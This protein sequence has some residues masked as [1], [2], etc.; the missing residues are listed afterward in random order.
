MPYLD[1]E[2]L[3]RSANALGPLPQSVTRL[4]ALLA[5]KDYD[6]REVVRTVE[7][8]ST[9]AGRIVRIANSAVYPG[10]RLSRVGDAIVRVGSGMIQAMAMEALARPEVDLDLSPFGLTTAEYWKHCVAVLSFAEE[11]AKRAKHGV[12]DQLAT[13]AL[14]HDFGKLVLAKHLTP[15]QRASLAASETDRPTADHEML[16]LGVNHAEVSAVVLQVWKLPPDVVAAVQYHHSPQMYDE[17]I[18]HALVVSNQLALR[19]EDHQE[20]YDRDTD[21]RAYSLD[22]LQIREPDFEA[23]YESGKVRLSDTLAVFES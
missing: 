9:L 4:S 23:A 13:A 8:D 1:H 20:A 16:V 15:A 21:L 18:T 5:D 22:A 10:A 2:K 3:V 7:L 11:I 19:A 12:G 6:L 14:L 17:P